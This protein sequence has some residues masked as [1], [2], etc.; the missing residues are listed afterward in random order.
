MSD[1]IVIPC[2]ECGSNM[3][4][5]STAA[6]KKVRCPKCKTVVDIP[7]GSSY[8]SDDASSDTASAEP[9][10]RRARRISE[11][12]A[13]S[14]PVPAA[15]PAPAV[16]PASLAKPVPIATPA[17]AKPKRTR[18]KAAPADDD[19][20]E[21]DEA[22]SYGSGGSEWDSYGNPAQVPQALPPRSKRKTTGS[23]APT[24]RGTGNEAPAAYSR[25]SGSGTN[26]SVV[27]GIL[28]MVGAAVWFFGG[29]AVGVIFFYPP[30]L[31]VLGFIALVKGIMSTE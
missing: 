6:G 9:Q 4:V 31:F 13:G 26:G 14:S 25:P 5:P 24:L 27:T 12:T 20:L 16:K 30:V 7:G 23:S 29:L 15:K 19:W 18:E 8:A 28:M 10:P 17:Q 11:P 3:S 22:S 21:D 1:K 2:S